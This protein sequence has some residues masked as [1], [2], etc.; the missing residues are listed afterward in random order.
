MKTNYT[1]INTAFYC[2]F[3]L[4]TSHENLTIT[5]VNPLNCWTFLILHNKT[6][7]LILAFWILF[8]WAIVSCL[9]FQAWLLQ[10]IYKP[11]VVSSQVRILRTDS[12]S[13]VMISHSTSLLKPNYKNPAFLQSKLLFVLLN[14]RKLCCLNLNRFFSLNW[15]ITLKKEL[16][17]SV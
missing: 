11:K 8:L 13:T 5:L 3:V 9:F 2:K 4:L 14:F 12:K 15:K 6:S 16:R 7:N 1:F 10:Y 17:L